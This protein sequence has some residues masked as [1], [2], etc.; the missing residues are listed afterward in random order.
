MRYNFF[1]RYSIL[2]LWFYDRLP[3]VKTI[4]L[5]GKL[6]GMSQSSTKMKTVVKSKTCVPHLDS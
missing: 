1:P 4:T 2:S 3:R 5:L 6:N